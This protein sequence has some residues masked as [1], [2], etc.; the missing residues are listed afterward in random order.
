MA[1]LDEGRRAA[2]G[3]FEGEEMGV[4]LVVVHC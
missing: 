3:S 4:G 1:K 2:D